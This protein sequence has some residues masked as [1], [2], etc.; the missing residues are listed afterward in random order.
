M[1]VAGAS[2]VGKSTFARA[3]SARWALPYTEIDALHWGDGWMPR[4]TF[5]DEAAAVAAAESWVAEFQYS[6]IR[7]TF[8]ARAQLLI[9][10]DYPRPVVLWRVLLR[11]VRRRLHRERLWS[12]DNVEPPLHT[13]LTDPDHI[14]RWSWRGIA[15]YRQ[16]VA[17]AESD[18]PGLRV[19]RLHTSRNAHRWL[20]STPR[21]QRQDSAH[22]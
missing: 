5:L 21:V 9:H 22:R 3:L 6:A 18:H 19:I 11:T 10:L 1:L 12:T 7:P 16:I 20:E 4:P 8:A 15:K 14:V 17:A 13:M 2:G